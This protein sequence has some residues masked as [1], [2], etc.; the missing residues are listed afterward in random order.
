MTTTSTTPVE[1]LDPPGGARTT[2]DRWSATIVEW[3]L[4]TPIWLQVLL[5]ALVILFYA[6]R[7]WTVFR[8]SGLFRRI[9]FDWGLFYAQAIA[10][11]NGD[12]SAMYQVDQLGGYVQR[13]APYTSTPDVPLLQWPAPYP[14]VLAAVLVPLTQVAP[15]LAFGIWTMLSLVAA[16]VLLWRVNQNAPTVGKTRAAVIFFTT[17]P[18]L[19]AFVLG[20]PVLFLAIAMA[21]SYLAL[22]R[23]ADFRGGAWLG[24][25]VLK[26]QYGLLM[27]LFLLWKRRW[28]AVAGACLG[29]GGVVVASALAAGPRSLLDYANGVSAMGD[30]RDPYAAAAEMVNWRSLIVNARPSIGNTS[31]VL[32]FVGLSVVTVAAIAWA[33]RGPWRSGSR[34]LE[35]QLLAVIV[36]TFLVSYHSHMHGLVLLTVPLAAMWSLSPRQPVV[37]LA[38]LAFIF[39]PTAA[40]IGVAGLARGFTINYED[41]LWVVWPVLNVALLTLLLV[42]T[43][44]PEGTRGEDAMT[45]EG[46]HGGGDHAL[47]AEGTH[48][49]NAITPEGS[50]GEAAI[51][52]EGTQGEEAITPEGTHGKEGTTPKGTHG[53]DAITPE[54]SM[55]LTPA[56]GDENSS[57]P[58]GRQYRCRPTFFWEGTHGE[59]AITP[60]GMT[61]G[62]VP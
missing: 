60:E 56:N 58:V 5:A 22:R 41:P 7:I 47:S 26:P 46:T 12:V 62:R 10:L 42:G 34:V 6:Q 54:D 14:P 13:L 21:E 4:A 9:G 1:T 53:D 52:P 20:Q 51:T 55:G 28:R 17:L 61:G 8:D 11:A 23:G 15:P 38:E 50:H 30:I 2:A 45:P 59:G 29:V 35:W 27:G 25:L 31:G 36:G 39:L 18:V 37:R 19:Q 57:F 49:A 48:S 16:V 33:T 3:V 24:L 40:F 43:L 32:L 44:S